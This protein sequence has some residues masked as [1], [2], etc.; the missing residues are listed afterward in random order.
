VGII[1]RRLGY[2][3]VSGGILGGMLAAPAILM[4]ILLFDYVD[5]LIFWAIGGA[6]VGALLLTGLAAF[7]GQTAGSAGLAGR[8]S[9]P[10]ALNGALVGS[11]LA[12]WLGAGALVFKRGMVGL[13]ALLT[14]VVAGGFLGAMVW[15]LGDLIGGQMITVEVLGRVNTWRQGEMIA[16]VPAGIL[17]GLAASQF[18]SLQR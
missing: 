7:G 10:I 13:I 14:S 15:M 1:A 11:V 17:S 6:V 8:F 18:L 3:D 5:E 4:L 9:L 16:G 12:T 2:A